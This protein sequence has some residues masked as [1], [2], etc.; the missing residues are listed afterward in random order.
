MLTDTRD[1]IVTVMETSARYNTQQMEGSNGRRDL[2]DCAEALRAQ[3]YTQISSSRR[4][5]MGQFFTPP[6]IARFMASLF[7]DAPQQ[8]RLLDPGA[9]VGILLAAVVED[10]LN[11]QHLPAKISV[12]AYEV[13]SLLEEYLR[14]IQRD[15]QSYCED[16][17]IEFCGSVR[18]EDFIRAGADILQE[19]LFAIERPSFNRVI[20]NPPYKKI[21]SNSAHR[22]LLRN[23]GIETSNLYTAFLAIA[24]ELLEPDGEMVAITPRSFCNGP[25]F[26]AF[27]TRFFEQ[28]TL[29]RIHLF[30]SRQEIFAEDEVLQENLIFYAVKNGKRGKIRLTTS[31]SPT[32]EGMTEREVAYE[33]VIRPDDPDQIIHLATV[34]MDDLVRERMEQF[35]HRLED[36]DIAVS[37]GRV[38]DFR[39]KEALRGLP[40]DDCAPLIYPLHL[41]NGAIRWPKPDSRKPNAIHISDST[42]ALLLPAGDYVVVKRFSSKEEP[43]RVVAAVYAETSTSASVVAFENHLNVFHWNHCGLPSDLARG[44]SV[45]LNST[46]VDSYFRQFNGHTQVNATDLRKLPYP[47]RETLARLGRQTGNEYPTQREIDRL[48]EREI[49]HMAEIESTDPVT[50]KEK[51]EAALHILESLG[52]PKGQQNDRSALTLLALLGLIPG[53]EWPESQDPLIGITPIMDFCRDHYGRNYA[54]NTRE[55][56]RR[57]TMHQFVQ[58]GLAIANPDDPG[59]AVNSPKYC[60]QIEPAALKLV[61]TYGTADWANTLR[62][63]LRNVE[64]LKQRYARAR[65]MKM[66]PVTL[67]EGQ[68][69]YLTPGDHSR[70][71]TAILDEFAPRFVP[72]GRVLYVG[73]TGGKWRFFDE[74]ALAELGVS[75]D[76]HGKM[77]D[78]VLHHTERG[79]LVLVEAVTSHGPVDPKRRQELSE[80]FIGS[81]RGLVYVTAFLRRSDMAKYAG[82]ISWETEVWVEESPSHLI[83]FDGERFLGPY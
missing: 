48:I 61:R 42:K 57:Q 40:D 43:R 25:Y 56:F 28:M 67:A 36:L 76:M 54:P 6:P 47:D 45:Y 8:L 64:T 17:G 1:D 39:A 27:R 35:T 19:G 16:S 20:L 13:E 14:Q 7:T 2:T 75:V 65:E 68:E 80:L 29:R 77:P 83:H 66:I 53:M 63:Y 9:G 72:G 32:D 60:Y 11:C 70:L 33:K 78:V 41:E 34:G 18:S 74:A 50:A 44:L 5:E 79:W 31:H 71:V 73:D 4:S 49:Q 46:L 24:A 51:I 23:I 15:C 81:T 10:V 58:A 69:L 59:R 37:T 22:L 12:I 38:V 3:A 62:S 52:F 55:T 82:E 21:S 26:K 30:D